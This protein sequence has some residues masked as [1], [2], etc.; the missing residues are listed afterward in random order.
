MLHGSLEKEKGKV[1]FLSLSF[2][3]LLFFSRL[4]ALT[5]GLVCCTSCWGVVETQRMLEVW[6]EGCGEPWIAKKAR[7]VGYS[8]VQSTHP[9]ISYFGC[10]MIRILMHAS[11]LDAPLSLFD[12]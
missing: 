7:C 1:W 12:G 11:V 4:Q 10:Y 5:L 6:L 9:I 8:L 2:P 3:L